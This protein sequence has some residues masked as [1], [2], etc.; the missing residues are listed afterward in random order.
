MTHA[1]DE[2]LNAKNK[3]VGE[4]KEVIGKVTN[5]EE[6][7][8]K[9]KLQSSTSD[10]KEKAEEVKENVAGKINEAIDKNE[11]GK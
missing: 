7:E 11:D 1:K 5:N 6:L 2:I 9:G 4:V 8:L 10:V 3:L